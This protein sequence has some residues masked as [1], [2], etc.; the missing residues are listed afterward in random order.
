MA[1]KKQPKVKMGGVC[2]TVAYVASFDDLN[3]FVKFHI[4]DRRIYAKMPENN[5]EA[6]LRDLYR[7][8]VPNG[9]KKGRPKRIGWS[10]EA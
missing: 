8:A 2:F 9:K 10:P 7:M 1:A 4:Q 6:M 5:R 3:D